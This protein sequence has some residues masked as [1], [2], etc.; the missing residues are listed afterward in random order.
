MGLAAFG[1]DFGV[2]FARP[3]SVELWRID[4]AGNRHAGT[5]VLPSRQGDIGAVSS[6]SSTGLLTS[7][8][9]DLTGAGDGPEAG[10]RRGLLLMQAIDR[11]SSAVE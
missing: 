7:T 6:V 3:E 4:Q 9:A 8:Y 5:L 11:L 1:N 10:D 2:L